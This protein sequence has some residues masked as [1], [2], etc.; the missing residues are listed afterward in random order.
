M[1]RVR[2]LKFCRKSNVHRTDGRPRRKPRPLRKRYVIRIDNCCHNCNF[3][4]RRVGAFARG[5]HSGGHMGAL[6]ATS[7]AWV[8]I[9]PVSTTGAF[10]L[11]AV[12]CPTTTI[13]TNYDY[14]DCPLVRIRV[15]ARHGPR[16]RWVRSCVYQRWARPRR[17][18][19]GAPPARL[20]R[21][22]AARESP[23]ALGVDLRDTPNCP[24]VVARV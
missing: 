17:E 10:S 9:S 14:G 8:V 24:P 20:A 15:A 22:Q 11:V 12:M 13:T 1:A 21:T 16:W 5:G 6:A 2:Q 7:A 23:S 18:R 3:G 4:I 19:A